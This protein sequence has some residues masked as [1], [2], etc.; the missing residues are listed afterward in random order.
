MSVPPVAGP[1]FGEPG[2][3]DEFPD[4]DEPTDAELLGLWPDPFAGPPDGD[5]AWL[6]DLSLPELDAL[7]GQWAAE[8][9][10]AAAREAIGAGFTRDVPGESPDGFAAGGPLDLLPPDPVLAGF[11]EDAYLA[12][13]GGLSDDEL[14]GMLGATRRLSSWQAAMEFAAVA[15]L[16]ARRRGQAGRPESSRVHD[17]AA[18]SCP[19]ACPAWRWLG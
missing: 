3:P 17:P 14:V 2:L 13:L 15:E 5:D 9:G 11:A 1:P 4:L 18:L 7:A 12:G 8:R 6:G 10:P 16:D 19:I